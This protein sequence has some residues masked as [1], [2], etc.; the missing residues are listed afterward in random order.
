MERSPEVEA[1]VR[2]WYDA[3]A[4]GDDAVIASGQ[5]ETGGVAVDSTHAYFTCARPNTTDRSIR[6]V[7]KTGGNVE[8]VIATSLEPLVGSLNESGS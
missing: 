7:P 1:V 5:F 6:R 4:R 2:R 8:T 3:I